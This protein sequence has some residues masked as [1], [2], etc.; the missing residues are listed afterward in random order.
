M[1]INLSKVIIC[2]SWKKQLHGVSK[3]KDILENELNKK[4][5]PKKL[6]R[7]VLDSESVAAIK[8][9]MSQVESQLGGLIQVSP[10]LIGNF[11]LK[12]RSALLTTKELEDLKA[13]N[14]DVIKALKMAMAEAI[15]AKHNGS[16]FDLNV[17][18]K[19][20]QTPG[21]NLNVTP[22]KTRGR[23]KKVNSFPE[24]QGELGEVKSQA[25]AL[26]G[27]QNDVSENTKLDSKP[28]KNDT[29]LTR[30]SP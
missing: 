22:K 21:V 29:N 6:D 15:K 1:A 10:K 17:L 24:A 28:L 20:I 2:G 12:K 5:K 25:A 23:K 30:N 3:V 26:N 7:I 18:L 14:H 27:L 16:E 8:N 11:I 13:E 19:N 4:L 9:V